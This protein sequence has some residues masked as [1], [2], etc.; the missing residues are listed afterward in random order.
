MLIFIL[1]IHNDINLNGASQPSPKKELMPAS[2][3][4]KKNN[5]SGEKYQ[6]HLAQSIRVGASDLK[7]FICSIA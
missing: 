5:I 1:A 7:L 3:N 4:L 6:F 2:K